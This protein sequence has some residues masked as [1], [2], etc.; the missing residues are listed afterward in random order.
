M[1]IPTFVEM[2]ATNGETFTAAD[3]VHHAARASDIGPDFTTALI[4]LLNPAFVREGTRILVEPVGAPARYAT[5][6][7][8]GQA[9]GEAEYWANLT[10]VSDLLADLDMAEAR[11]LA[12]MFRWCWQNALAAQ[13]PGATQVVRVLEDRKE[14]EVYVTVAEPDAGVS[15]P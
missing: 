3:Y 13:H 14:N 4:V 8:Q 10:L 9:E 6:R 2:R 5:Y 7:A 1:P 12:Q 15:R 11:K